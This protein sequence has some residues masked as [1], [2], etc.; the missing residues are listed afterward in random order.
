MINRIKILDQ[1]NAENGHIYA[2]MAA[3]AFHSGSNKQSRNGYR[4]H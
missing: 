2:G 4:R 1:F 3:G